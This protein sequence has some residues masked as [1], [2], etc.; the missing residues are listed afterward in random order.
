MRKKIV[1][2]VL[3]VIVIMTLCSTCYSVSAA[4]DVPT[5]DCRS[6]VLMDA[7]T[8]Q[9]LYDKG[10]DDKRY[11]ASITKIMTAILTIEKGDYEKILTVNDETLDLE[12]GSSV[13]NLK[14][15]EE[16]SVN[17]A[18][19]G[20]MLKSGNDAANLLAQSLTTDGTLNGFGK[21]MTDK[22]KE[23][24]AVN[25]N[26][27][28]ANGLHDDNHYTTAY[29]MALITKYALGLPKFKDLISTKEYTIPATNKNEA[30]AYENS[31]KMI[32]SGND[33]YY[34]YA[35][36]GKTGFTDQA[37]NTLVE[38][39]V[40]DGVELISVVMFSNGQVKQYGNTKNLLEFGFNQFIPIKITKDMLP[41][42][43]IPVKENGSIKYKTKIYCDYEGTLLVPAEVTK[44][45]IIFDYSLPGA[46]EE[47]EELDIKLSI[48]VPGIYSSFMDTTIKTLSFKRESSNINA[49]TPEPKK[50][51]EGKPM[52][53]IFILLIIVG[54][55]IVIYLVLLSI[56]YYNLSKKKKRKKN[57]TSA[58]RRK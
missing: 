8:G 57:K 12:R 52:A 4:I 27:T 18:L 31:N 14:V 58:G 54:V 13:I 40:K 19:Y 9:I 28:N 41:E 35:V 10:K 55:C 22:A 47:S 45:D 50:D 23:I 37:G 3:A 1:S 51:E 42:E 34:E 56:R 24:G 20:M 25:T 21:M 17:N 7:K 44:E 16:I 15:G 33:Y 30:R 32:L 29:D 6:A 46:I 38:Y 43:T 5:L 11:P 2:I 39:A 48:K 36:G 26:F 49:N 53:F